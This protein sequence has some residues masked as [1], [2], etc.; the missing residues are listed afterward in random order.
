MTKLKKLLALLL[1]LAM[2]FCLAACGGN[3]EDE[4]KDDKKSSKKEKLS[5][6][7]QYLKDLEELIDE[8]IEAAENGDE[9]KVDELN[10]ELEELIVEC[11]EIYN[12]LAEEDEDAADK[13]QMDVLEIL[14]DAYDALEEYEAENL[15]EEERIAG[16][17][18]CTLDMSTIIDEMLLAEL[19]EESLIPNVAL[20]MEIRFVFDQYGGVDLSMEINENSMRTYMDALAANMV[21]YMYDLLGEMGYTPSAVDELIESEYGMTLEE[22][23]KASL[24]EGAGD[25]LNGFSESMSGYYKL[26]SEAKHIYMG[27]TEADLEDTSEYLVYELNGNELKLVD[28][29][30]DDD[31]TLAEMAQYGME[32][33]WVFV[34]Q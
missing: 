4:D 29:V 15:T 17:W 22:Y 27:E 21:E 26:D 25:A 19:G 8:L 30:S 24:E 9:D 28:A 11:E 14:E 12:N 16:E 32:F 1:A 10:E 33:P 7:E 34:K 13:F 3:D 5:E 20:N 2:V 18:L 6:E 31:S 23:A